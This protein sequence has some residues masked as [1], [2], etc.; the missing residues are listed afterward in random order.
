[1]RHDTAYSP[2]RPA[3]RKPQ[4]RP[5]PTTRTRCRSSSCASSSSPHTRSPQLLARCFLLVSLCWP[6]RLS[7]FLLMRWVAF[8]YLLVRVRVDDGDCEWCFGAKGSVVRARRGGM[9]GGRIGTSSAVSSRP[10]PCR[11]LGARGACGGGISSFLRSRRRRVFRGCGLV[12]A[13][14]CRGGDGALLSLSFFRLIFLSVAHVGR[15][16]G[17]SRLER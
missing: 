2:P 8:R 5:R 4:S 9:V 3:P 14:C 10:R 6:S 11:P 1:M 13:V 16:D 15:R 7:L 12:G 17:A